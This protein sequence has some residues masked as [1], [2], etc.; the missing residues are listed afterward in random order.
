MSISFSLIV[1]YQNFGAHNKH[2]PLNIIMMIHGFFLQKKI[3]P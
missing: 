2:L 1:F 3:I